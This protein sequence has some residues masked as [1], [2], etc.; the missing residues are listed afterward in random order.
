MLE[1]AP[2]KINIPYREMY[3]NRTRVQHQW[4]Q[5]HE[6][7]DGECSLYTPQ[8]LV[9]TF[10]TRS[11]RP[12]IIRVSDTISVNTLFLEELCINED[13]TV[14]PEGMEG[15]RD[16]DYKLADA[17]GAEMSGS[18]NAVAS[19]KDDASVASEPSAEKAA[20]ADS[21]VEMKETQHCAETQQS[22]ESVKTQPSC[23]TKE[24][25]L[26]HSAAQNAQDEIEAKRMRLQRQDSKGSARTTTPQPSTIVKEIDS[27]SSPLSVPRI[28]RIEPVHYNITPLMPIPK[29]NASTIQ[30]S[31]A[32]ASRMFSPMHY[33]YCDSNMSSFDQDFAS[34]GD[35]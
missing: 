11:A 3:Q 2:P 28:K 24:S 1:M 34:K 32:T 8:F 4:K 5:V 16:S 9:R 17:A 29:P 10:N 33:E 26:K 13:A 35:N 12:K 7:L 6:H 27:R 23:R 15:I 18:K 20:F 31:T 30:P 19:E 14:S 22:Q 21:N 25:P